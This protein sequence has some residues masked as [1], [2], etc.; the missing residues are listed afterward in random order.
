[1]LNDEAPPLPF[2]GAF[3]SGGGLSSLYSE[4]S[5]DLGHACFELL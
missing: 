2:A 3:G 5:L 1:M 4:L